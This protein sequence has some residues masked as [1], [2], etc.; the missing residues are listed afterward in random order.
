MKQ[1]N[2]TRQDTINEFLKQVSNAWKNINEDF[3]N[4]TEVAKPLL[5]PALNISRVMDLL[6]K[7]EDGYT[8]SKGSTKNHIEALLLNPY[9]IKEFELH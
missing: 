4:P 2:T 7:D 6:Y 3:L 8:H 5:M 9:P 1:Q